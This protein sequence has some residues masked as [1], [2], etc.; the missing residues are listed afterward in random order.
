MRRFQ[1]RLWTLVPLAA[2]VLLASGCGKN[3]SESAGD[4]SE[5]TKQVL[6]L[7][8]TGD[9]DSL[10]SMHISTMV[11]FNTLN[12][13]FEGLVGYDLDGKLI[14]TGAE[15]LPEISSD[16]TVY[17]F[18]IRSDAKWSNGEDVTAD[19]YVYTWQKIVDPA[20]GSGYS[21]MVDG[22][23]KNAAEIYAGEKAVSELGVKAID[24]KT[25]EVTLE[26]PTPY[27]MQLLTLPYFFP[28]NR[29]FATEKGNEYGI[30]SDKILYNGPFEVTDWSAAKGGAWK[31]VKN[32]DYWDKGN[33]KLDE[34]DFQVIK[35]TET[36]VNLYKSDELD[37]VPLSGN[38]VQEFQSDADYAERLKSRINY[39]E[40]NE[41]TT[42]LANQNIRKAL[43]L[44]IDTAQFT[45]NV[46]QDGSIVS[47]GYVPVGL[48]KNP[49]TGADFRADAGD[50]V[51]YNLATAQQAWQ[52]G[53][54]EIGQKA[55]TLTLTISDT[56]EHKKLAE[57]V[58]SQLQENL[59]G[60]TIEIK[61]MPESSRIANVKAGD[62]QLAA[63][64]WEA[65]FADPIN[66]VERFASDT[67]RGHYSFADVDA[68]VAQSKME[69][70]DVNARWAT[71]VKIEQAA[72]GEHYV[73]IPLY[74][75]SE[76]YLQKAYVKDI[77][78]PV[79]GPISY[80]Y[81]SVATE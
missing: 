5:A 51:S 3:A 1:N 36:G 72:L 76:A 81:A 11:A 7:S 22:V 49:E 16:Q 54:A 15:A 19:D 50:L 71:L 75:S 13:V 21:Y 56:E 61:A 66:Y 34:V 80:R 37:R 26:K 6:H 48:A 62:Y 79:S 43:A 44:A 29:T 60:L 53:L 55:V 17:T 10:D 78:T 2:F 33:V 25:L 40:M 70:N 57:F 68:L 74:Q 32:E 8:E 42:E 73:H 77:Y 63:A 64:Y 65:D 27:F 24:D 52:Q 9:M 46:L 20:V 35:D 59:P 23:I 67:N 47:T 39:I 18:K 30:A 12:N 69:Y 58:Q 14:A 31:L 38:F 4:T 45:E 28:Q 41:T